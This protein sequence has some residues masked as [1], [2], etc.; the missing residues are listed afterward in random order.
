MM[1]QTWEQFKQYKTITLKSH[2]FSQGL[3]IPVVCLWTR[4]RPVF[5]Y[6]S[7]KIISIKICDTSNYTNVT[8]ALHF[9]AP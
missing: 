4:N 8:I 3:Q 7:R 6:S 2:L 5:K 9:P 1:V